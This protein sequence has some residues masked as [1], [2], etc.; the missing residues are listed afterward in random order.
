MT[1]AMKSHDL[2]DQRS[3][4]FGQAIAARLIEDPSLVDYARANISRWVTTCS[5]GVRRTLDEWVGVLDEGMRSILNTLTGSG[6]RNT[7]LR[8]SNP[9][10]GLLSEQERNAFLLKFQ[11]Y[12]KAST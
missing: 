2:I 10:A 11:A 7:R 1:P 4:A 9:F 3:L 8:Q 5:P 12:D 6:E